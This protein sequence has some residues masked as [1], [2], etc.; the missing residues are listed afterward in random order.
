M[1]WLSWTPRRRAV[2]S[3]E[4]L[5]LHTGGMCLCPQRLLVLLFFPLCH[6]RLAHL[7]P[8]RCTSTRFYA[9]MMGVFLLFLLAGASRQRAAPSTLAA[10]RHGGP[11]RPKQRD[12]LGPGHVL[13]PHAARGS[14]SAA[15]ARARWP[16]WREVDLPQDTRTQ[17]P[18]RRRRPRGGGCW[19]VCAVLTWALYT[20]PREQGGA[21]SHHQSVKMRASRGFWKCV[22]AMCGTDFKIY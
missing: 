1:C 10:T 7:P 14:R 3:P 2:G 13:H 6:P 15:G 22:A 19:R 11:S 5:H 18:G 17:E 20:C 4:A 16:C 21:G 12:G 8:G 9:G